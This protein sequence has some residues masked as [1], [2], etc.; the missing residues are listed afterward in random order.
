M[1]ARHRTPSPSRQTENT[2]R[3]PSRSRLLRS[4]ARGC[5]GGFA[6]TVAMTVYRIPAFKALPPTAEFWGRYVGGGD[7]E[8]YF[9]P[10]LLLHLL[11]GV[12][13]GA[14]YGLV[15]SFA[16]VTDPVARER[17]SVLSGLGYALALSAFGSRVVFVRLLGRELQS[18]DA[19]VFHVGHAIYGATLGTFVATSESSG[20]VYRKSRRTRPDTATQR[21]SD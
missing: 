21:A 12:A 17:L 19:L 8:E 7:V 6:A 9:L 20:D 18:E 16:D 3:V 4:V 5:V 13:G 1:S 11:Y 2:F 10:G 15:A 14:V